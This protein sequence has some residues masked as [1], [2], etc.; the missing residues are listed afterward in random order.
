VA[1]AISSADMHDTL[2]YQRLADAVLLVHFGVVVFIVGGLVAIVLGNHLRWAWVNRLWLRVTHL[3]A[4]GVVAAE[5][6]LGQACPLTRLESSLRA[7]AGVAPYLDTFIAHWTHRLL[8]YDAPLWLF[9]LLYTAFGLLVLIAWWK[10]PPV[11]LQPSVPMRLDQMNG[12][13]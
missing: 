9:T 11:R 4:I 2:L 8:F 13:R 6:W 12:P 10:F 3:V 7:K 1:A 5:A